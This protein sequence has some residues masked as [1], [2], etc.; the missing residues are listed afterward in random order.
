MKKDTE[1]LEQ[2]LDDSNQMIQV[3]DVETFS[4]MYANKPARMYTGHADQPY[5][6]KHCYEYMMGLSEKCPFCP[7]FQLG[8]RDSFETEID[9]GKQIFAVKT[10]LIECNGVRSRYTSHRYRRS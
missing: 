6:G 3:S 7:M 2:I 4:M 8:D 5:E 10:K 9:N 1:L